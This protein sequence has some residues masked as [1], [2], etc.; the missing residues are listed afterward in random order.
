MIFDINF[1]RSQFPILKQEIYGK[2]LIYL[3]NGATTQKPHSVLEKMRDVYENYNSN[4]HRGVHHLSNLCT[5]MHENARK[6]VAEHINAQSD[7][8]IVFT[9]GTTESINLLAYSF[10]ESY[11]N[12]GDE[13]I[14][15]TMEH[16]SNIVPW[17]LLCERKKMNL[18]VAPIDANGCLILPELYKLFNERTKLLA[19]THV[20]N[21]TG[22]INPVEEIVNEAHAH[23]IPV[24]IDAAQSMPHM[25]V[26]VQAIDCD[27]MAFSGH[28]MYGP[29]GI[30]VLY[31]RRR[32]MDDMVPYQAG[33]AM[34]D[35]VTLEKTTFLPS[36]HRFEAGTPDYVGAI[37]LASAVDYIENIGKKAICDHE[38][39]LVEYALEGLR[40]I[41]GVRIIGEAEE[42]AGVVSFL[43]GNAHPYDT[44]MIL[45]KMGIAV[46]TGHHCAQPLMA[47][48]GI[49]GTVR[50]SFAIYNNTNDVDALIDGVRRVK[51][52]LCK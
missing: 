51:T 48:F 19:I 15:S 11:C 36:P 29:N 45:D 28:K 46:R 6:R 30:G 14:I 10:G 12:E 18:R 2:P 16:H 27:F 22:I 21:V 31:G 20:S 49:P 24:L 25:L 26:D 5:D 44:G 4:V 8:E 40:A 38:K 34:I 13:I 52:M 35:K 39:H 32:F 7:R 50:A 37:G 17:Q 47:H 9:R 1:F 33:G 42:R 43:V 3:D 41:D 23:H